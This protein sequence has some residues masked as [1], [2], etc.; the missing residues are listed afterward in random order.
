LDPTGYDATARWL[1]YLHP[2]WMSVSLVLVAVTLRAGLA[3]RRRRLAGT[4]PDAALIRRHLRYAKPAVVMVVLGFAGGPVSALWLREW[5][6]FATLH[7]WL[8]LLSLALFSLAGWL[9]WLLTERRSED[10][11]THGWVGLMATL[12]AALTAFAGFVLL[13]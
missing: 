12:A 8:G 4:Q 13:P 2:L 1:A 9:G 6:A 11:S 10:A 5:D 7:A 3:M